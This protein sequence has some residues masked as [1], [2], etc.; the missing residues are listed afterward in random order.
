M[1]E[2]RE[3]TTALCADLGLDADQ[4]DHAL[5]LAMTRDVG[6]VIARQAAPITAF[7]V[8]MAVARGLPPAEAAERLGAL[9]DDW[10]RFDWRD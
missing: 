6:R 8:G 9:T 3:W 4:C 2:L 1:D 5:V 7:L 10:P